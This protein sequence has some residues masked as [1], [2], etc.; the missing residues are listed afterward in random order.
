QQGP[1]AARVG[2]TKPQSETTEP[3]DRRL[4]FLNYSKFRNDI[5]LFRFDPASPSFGKGGAT[6]VDVQLR[7]P[8]GQ[9]LVWC[10]GGED[11]VLSVR[12]EGHVDISSTIVGFLVKDRLGQPLFGDNTRLTY[13]SRPVRMKG[14]DVFEALFTFRM[15]ILPVGDYSVCVSAAEGTQME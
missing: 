7:D 8:D 4:A 14:G 5:E 3:R 15:P 11:V 2:A 12:C 13:R 10:V 1:S 6:I 9:R